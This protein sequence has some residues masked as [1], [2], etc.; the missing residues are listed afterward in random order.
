MK[1]S[2]LIIAFLLMMTSCSKLNDPPGVDD[3]SS[4]SIALLV[5]QVPTGVMDA[6][7]TKYPA[8]GGEIEWEKED[9]NTYKVKFWLGAERWQ[10]VFSST[11]GFLSDKRLK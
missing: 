9:S 10:A 3:S 1:N 5:S 4:N 7:K 11:G 2:F 8:A 6:F